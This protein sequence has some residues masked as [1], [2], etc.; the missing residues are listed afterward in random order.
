MYAY[1][2]MN[3]AAKDIVRPRP[4]ATAV[5]TRDLTAAATSQPVRRRHG[6]TLSPK[7]PTVVCHTLQSAPQ[8]MPL[9]ANHA[10]FTLR[11]RHI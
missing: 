9:S 5:A 7:T 8:S 10:A 6:V 2:S 3:E 1:I 11:L 4:T